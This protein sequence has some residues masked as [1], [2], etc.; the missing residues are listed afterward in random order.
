M[1]FSN[2]LKDSDKELEN[3]LKLDKI[4]TSMHLRHYFKLLNKHLFLDS[5]YR[6]NSSIHRS[7]PGY[8]H[9]I[10]L[11]NDLLKVLCDNKHLVKENERRFMYFIDTENVYS[12]E[13]VFV[14]GIFKLNLNHYE[15]NMSEKNKNIVSE[16]IH[17]LDNL[18]EEAI[19]LSYLDRDV[20]AEKKEKTEAEKDKDYC[21]CFP[22]NKRKNEL[23]KTDS[24][25][26][27]AKKLRSS[28]PK[29]NTDNTDKR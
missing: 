9:P 29:N 3:I 5:V 13:Y 26:P 14:A 15:H 2:E 10:Q 20:L 18:L 28:L 27:N 1:D 16:K 24:D 22:V 8:I 12:F 7:E 17:I 19:N 6:S 21:E 25:E 11:F 4:K 23:N